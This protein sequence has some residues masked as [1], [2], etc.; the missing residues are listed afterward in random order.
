[1]DEASGAPGERLP[2]L[3]ER[4]VARCRTNREQLAA[5]SRRA[6]LEAR[7]A[8]RR[9]QEESDAS[10]RTTRAQLAARLM[11]TAREVGGTPSDESSALAVV[12]KRVADL[13]R[14][15]GQLETDDRDHHRLL[16]LLDGSSLQG[17]EEHLGELDRE[18]AK[19]GSSETPEV[20]EASAV[21]LAR[22]VERSQGVLDRTRA[23]ASELQGKVQERIRSMPDVVAAEER[24]RAAET[25]IGR[26]EA[27]DR[28]LERTI[29]I[30]EEAKDETQREI[31]PRLR[32]A[33]L[34]QLPLATAGRYVDVRIDPA[35]LEVQVRERDG[36]WRSAM[37]LSHGTAE[38]IYLLLRIALART[39]VS[40]AETAPLLL[41]DVTVQ[42]DAERVGAILELLHRDSTERQVIL[43]SQQD[44]V[45]AWARG[46]LTEPRDRLIE[47]PRPEMMLTAGG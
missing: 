31:A 7:L 22:A 33:I 17:L 30:L 21:E 19:F 41:D 26:I 23:A 36:E 16:G 8:L 25:A 14:R 27:L 2:A 44:V 38:Q 29:S 20:S 46:R 28:I 3:V 13:D 32:A 1:V 4:Y 15:R 11:A 42:S 12:Q 10:A 47:L 9:R 5:A 37:A 40:T 45:L 34:P 43:F 24:H 35:T 18:L 6:D 39:L